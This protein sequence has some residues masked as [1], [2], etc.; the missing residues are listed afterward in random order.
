[1]GGGSEYDSGW[2]NNF[3]FLDLG[4]S[5]YSLLV[6]IFGRHLYCVETSQL[7]CRASWL[8]GFCM[9]QDFAGGIFEQ[10]IA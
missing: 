7:I 2:I 6:K 10:T 8:A 1:M 4:M 5:D 3:L 9:V